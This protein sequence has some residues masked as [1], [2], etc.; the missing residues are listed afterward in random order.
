L[1]RQI[2]ERDRLNDPHHSG[3][4]P[5]FLTWVAEQQLPAL[6]R[7]QHY[8]NQFHDRIAELQL[9]LANLQKQ[10]DGGRL[11]LEPMAGITRREIRELQD[12]MSAEVVA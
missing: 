9:R 7:H 11:D 10:I 6:A 8:R 2:E 5:A 1:Q 12:L 4:A 3:P